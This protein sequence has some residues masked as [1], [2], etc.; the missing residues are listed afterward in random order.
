MLD[1][2]PG[3]RS[4]SAPSGA[5]P[6]GVHAETC[7]RVAGWLISPAGPVRAAATLEHAV[8]TGWAGPGSVA[9]HH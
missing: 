1:H 6:G 7:L 5:G 3:R 9:F 8:I 2:V 4:G